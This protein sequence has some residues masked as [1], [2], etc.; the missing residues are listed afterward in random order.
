MFLLNLEYLISGWALEETEFLPLQILSPFSLI[1][2]TDAGW[3][4][5]VP[6]YDRFAEGF[7]NLTLNNLKNDV[8]FAIGSHDGQVRLGWA[9]RTDK[10]APG[11]FF[12]RFSRTL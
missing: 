5:Y 10:N 6:S 7:S 8:G 12:F 4:E 11:R 2:F 9:W 3:A 1:I